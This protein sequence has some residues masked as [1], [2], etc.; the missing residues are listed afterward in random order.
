MGDFGNG[1]EGDPQ[2]IIERQSVEIAR[3]R[4]EREAALHELEWS[5][6]LLRRCQSTIDALMGDSDLDD[7]DSPEMRL[8]LDLS[9]HLGSEPL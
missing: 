4:V 9:I 1:S 6:T 2:L 7:D 3:L 5:K 8:M